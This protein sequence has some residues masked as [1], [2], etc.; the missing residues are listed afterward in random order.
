MPPASN[1]PDLAVRLRRLLASADLD[2]R[3]RTRLDDALD[4]FTA[5]ERRQAL[6][7]SL[8]NARRQRDWIAA[9]LAALAELDQITEQESDHT[10]FDEMALL[11]QEIAAEAVAAA[12]DLR[13]LRDLAAPR[14]G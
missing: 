11:F 6:R 13:E 8:R 12:M 5:L 3:C 7:R 10:V 9:Q 2:C 1:P 14:K 4:R